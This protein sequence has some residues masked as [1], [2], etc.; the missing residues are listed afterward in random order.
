ML[1]SVLGLAALGAGPVVQAAPNPAA[2]AAK[3]RVVK[4]WTPERRAAAIPRDLVIDPRGLGYLKMPD[5]SLRPYG[6]DVAATPFA[7]P[8]NS[9]DSTPPN[10]VM[11]SPAEGAEIGT[12]A[13]F[14]ADITDSSGIKSVSFVILYPNGSTT[15]SF[16]PAQTAGTDTWSTTLQGFSDGDWAWSVTAKDSAGKGGNTATTDF[17][18][19]TVNSGGGSSGN[20]T[21]GNGDTVVNGHWSYGGG[22]QTAAGRIYFEM[23]SNAKLKGPWNGYVCSGTV[24][25]DETAGRSVILTAAHCVYDD[26]NK[27]FA[28]NVLFIPN[29]D[30]TTG[31]GTDLN[32]NNDPLGCWIP[33][34]GVVDANWTTSTFPDNIPWDYAHYVVLDESL[35]VD[36]G[37]LP[38]SFDPPVVDDGTD[39]AGSPDFTHA[40]GY[41][42]SDDPNFMYCA[43]DMT[44]EGT[45]N[46]WL[47]SCGLSGGSSGG[48]WV[49]PMDTSTGSGAVISVNSWGYTTSPGM[50]G[51]KLAG[52]SASCVF[53]EAKMNLDDWS[54]VA[55]GEA[56]VAIICE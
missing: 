13:T 16:T 29:Q 2:E 11:N 53:E 12:S 36:A 42:Y 8:P 50:A 37:S 24:V 17:S 27:A 4:H 6:H 5:G 23:P 28:K 7:G 22:V 45:D 14:S 49:Q 46:W 26:A 34:F 21:G 52:T 39:G 1:V 43:E 33:E 18:G 55:D 56:G 38:L 54:G 32:C 44:T 25:T 20:N 40:L 47:P 15:Q 3:A 31:S 19:F 35:E 10:I 48:P 9:G 51:P 41:S 30:E